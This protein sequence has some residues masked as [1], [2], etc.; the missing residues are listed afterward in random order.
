MEISNAKSAESS[1]SEASFALRDRR[2]RQLEK[3]RLLRS[4]MKRIGS[5][6]SA[7]GL[8]LTSS[9]GSFDGSVETSLISLN[10]SR[11]SGKER[12]MKKSM[13][14]DKVPVEFAFGLLTSK[15]DAPRK[16]VYH[17]KRSTRRSDDSVSTKSS[18]RLLDSSPMLKHVIT[19]AGEVSKAAVQN[20][21]GNVIIKARSPYV[22]SVV[23]DS[24]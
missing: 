23:R 7:S 20:R 14:W 22:E 9:G 19:K 8:S 4:R 24:K 17:G 5:P 16:G 1:T 10:Q 12:E 21:S 11:S 15:D 18:S 13:K 3:E 2:T 6:D